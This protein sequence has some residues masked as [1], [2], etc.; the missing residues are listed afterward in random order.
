MKR[1]KGSD[2][3]PSS[4]YQ[5][6]SLKLHRVPGIELEPDD[7]AIPGDIAVIGKFDVVLVTILERNAKVSGQSVGEVRFD[8]VVSLESLISDS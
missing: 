5:N 1:L 4:L 8:P 2:L 6:R 3:L 7:V